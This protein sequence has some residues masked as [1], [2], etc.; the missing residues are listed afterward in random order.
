MVYL[1][2]SQI[3]IAS[4]LLLVN[5]G[6]S[7]WLSLR[8]ERPIIIAA[9]RMVLQLVTVGFILRYVFRQDNV[10]I[11]L[12][13]LMVMTLSAGQACVS[14]CKIRYKG[15]WLD[16]SV[17]LMASSW[18]VGLLTLFLVIQ[19]VPWYLP[20][21]AIPLMGMILGNSLNGITLGQQQFVQE[22]DLRK[23][24][25]NSMLAMGATS[26]EAALPSIRSALQ[27]GM[28]PMLNSMT[29]AGLVS[30]PGMMTGQI[31]GGIDP[32]EAV[33]Y[34]IV[35]MFLIASASAIGTLISVALCFN[36]AFTASHQ[37]VWSTIATDHNSA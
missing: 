16:A 1:T 8:L 29:I 18:I 6:I 23:Q 9:I 14:R 13:C 21:Y 28:T 4:L 34:Q 37:F 11:V 17:S 3:V 10:A 20:Q 31:L 12:L 27:T 32:L 25:I 26:Y 22:L 7:I 19:P 15:F 2:T 5:A 33:K 36:R 30:L 24:E 35:I